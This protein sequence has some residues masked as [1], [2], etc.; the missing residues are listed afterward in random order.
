ML[1]KGRALAGDVPNILAA[2]G[3]VYALGGE[4]GRAREI[5]VQLEQIR[6]QSY[7]PSTS[8]AVVHLGLRETDRA[9]DWLEN[10]CRQHELPLTSIKV[11]PIYTPLRTH[12]RF[13][14]LLRRVGF[15]P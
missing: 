15:A 14:E 8:F 13:R 12:P 6:A 2:M 7:V 10:G 4:T 9:L 11:H 3:Q 5:L 1:E